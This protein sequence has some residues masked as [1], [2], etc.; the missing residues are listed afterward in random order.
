MDVK[1]R[2]RARAHAHTHTHTLDITTECLRTKSAVF[3]I[4][5]LS[6]SSQSR[7]CDFV[8]CWSTDQWTNTE[9]SD[10]NRNRSNCV[11]SKWKKC[12]HTAIS[13]PYGFVCFVPSVI[14]VVGFFYCQLGIVCGH[15]AGTMQRI[16][17]AQLVP[18]RFTLRQF[19]IL[20]FWLSL[21]SI[22]GSFS[23]VEF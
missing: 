19:M 10:Y 14:V 11:A 13:F 21:F 20:F 9:S 16:T 8:S 18:V 12:V 23:Y 22:C 3:F 15:S 4:A 2:A 6:E 1:L 17:I 5:R 7:C